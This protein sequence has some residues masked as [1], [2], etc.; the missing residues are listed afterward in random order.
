MNDTAI[1]S[2]QMVAAAPV[3][4]RNVLNANGCLE[5]QGFVSSHNMSHIVD[6]AAQLIFG[7]KDSQEYL[8]FQINRDDVI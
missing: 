6:V 2:Q 1:L 7:R 3:A 4:A 8:P 5:A